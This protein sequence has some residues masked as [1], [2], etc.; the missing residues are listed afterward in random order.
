MTRFSFER[1]RVAQIRL[2]T[3]LLT[4]LGERM[5]W[6]VIRARESALLGPVLR[7]LLGYRGTFPSFAA[8]TENIKRNTGR[9][10]EFDHG[11]QEVKLH[12][13]LARTVRESDYPVLFHLA[14]LASNLRSVFDL[15]GSIGNLFYAYQRL[16]P[17][18]PSLH[19]TVL[20]LGD[21]RT[22]GEELARERGETRLRYAATLNDASGVDLLLISGS[23][24]YFEQPIDE[25]LKPL[26]SLPARVIVNRTPFSAGPDLISVQDP[27]DYLLPCKLYGRQN[28]IAAMARLGYSL[29]DSWP[30]HERRYWVPLYPEASHYTYFG[31]YFELQPDGAVYS[32][33]S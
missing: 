1:F 28:F 20:D 13:G 9:L 31:F 8:A 17:F 27:G 3:K 12:V 5:P 21:A 26:G 2:A 4:K 32:G 14:P 33:H 10:M 29:R 22:A 16:L 18:S 19:W 24:H 23:L 15:G 30:V 6:V 11:A 25:L 7:A